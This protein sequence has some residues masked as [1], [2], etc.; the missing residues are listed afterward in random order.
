VK[1]ELAK[2]LSKTKV[3]KS[4]DFQ[5]YGG[6]KDAQD[7]QGHEYVL[8]GPYETGKTLYNLH[9]LNRRLW[10][11]PNARAAITRNTYNSLL[12]TAIVTFENKVLP[13]H[14]DDPKSPIKK[15]GRSKPEFYQYP[16]GSHLLLVGLDKP[17]K[18]LSGE[19]DYILFVQLEE[20]VLNSY[21]LALGRCTGRAGNVPYPQ[22]MSDCNPGDPQHWI[23]NRPSLTVFEQLHQHNPTLFDQL[24]QAWT[25]QGNRTRTIL[26][27]LTGIRYKRGFLGLWAGVEGAVYD[28][29]R[30]EHHA[31]DAFEIPKRWRRF[32]AIDFGYTNA[33]VCQWW[34]VDPDG[35]LY[36][37]REIYMSQRTVEDHGKQIL[38]YSKGERFEMTIADHDPGAHKTLNKM[39]IPTV[40]AVKDIELGIEKVQLRL[41]DAGDGKPRLYFFKDVRVE[42]DGVLE[43]SHKPTSTL[44]EITIY[45]YPDGVDGKPNKEIPID[46]NNHGMDTMRYMVMA[47]EHKKTKYF[48]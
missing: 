7:Y 39:G 31:I 18:L 10:S 46:D 28:G 19:F 42:L 11:Y 5:F 12:S 22:I 37:Y 29:Y 24:K 41:R 8:S 17:Q 38:E 48:L 47:L 25:E 26:Q 15:Y 43:D 33:F 27:G 40:N 14:P 32:R 44:Q 36:M 3:K 4:H 45:S 34:A 2:R 20:V 16:N 21:E 6:A 35:R 23:L 1:V 13:I 30:Y 9:E